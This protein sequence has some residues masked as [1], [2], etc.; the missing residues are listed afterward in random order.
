MRLLVN[1]NS[2]P[3]VGHRLSQTPNCVTLPSARVW[4][5]IAMR[6]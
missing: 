3:H 6:V 4:G 5:R 2:P 1:V